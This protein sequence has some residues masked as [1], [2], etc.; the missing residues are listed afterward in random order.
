ME[1]G[2]KGR[3]EFF[4]PAEKKRERLAATAAGGPDEDDVPLRSLALSMCFYH[5][6]RTR[7]SKRD[8]AIDAQ[9]ASVGAGAG[10]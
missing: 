5:S 3:G 4:T 10:A 9:S 2:G 8:A 7:Q 1:G 6:G